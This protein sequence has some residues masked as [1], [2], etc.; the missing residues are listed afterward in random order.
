MAGG[1]L[2]EGPVRDGP[3]GERAGDFL[4]IVLGI[5][6]DAQGE[7]FHHL[8]RQVLVGMPLAVG[9]RVEIDKERRIP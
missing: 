2:V 7:Q 1:H 5:V 4:D 9:R 8:A 3:A 6:A